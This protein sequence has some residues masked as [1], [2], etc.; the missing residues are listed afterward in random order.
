MQTCGTNEYIYIINVLE[1]CVLV[2]CVAE[3]T[4]HMNATKFAVE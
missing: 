4:N 2:S 1:D 3:D